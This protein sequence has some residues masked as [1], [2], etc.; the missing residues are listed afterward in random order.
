MRL[1]DT[2]RSRVYKSERKVLHFAKPL[3]EVK[4]I[5]RFIKKQLK[6]KA[7]TR[8]YPDATREVLVHDGGGKRN[9]SAYGGWKISIP[10]W[11]RSD[12]IVIHELAHIVAHRHYRGSSIASHGWQFCAIYLDLVRFIMGRE[13]HDALKASFKAHK[14]RFTQPRTRA[15]MSPERKAELAARLA[16]A[17]AAKAAAAPQ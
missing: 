16:A 4:D 14:V 17:R 5:E 2:Q 8:R 1:R 15:P 6:R 11:A 3:R 13:A 7:I 9:A 12:L 10:L